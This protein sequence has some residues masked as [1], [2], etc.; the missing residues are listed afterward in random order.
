MA[1]KLNWQK[2]YEV[3]SSLRDERSFNDDTPLVFVLVMKDDTQQKR[4]V[5]FK[6]FLKFFWFIYD[7]NRITVK[8]LV[9]QDKAGNVLYKHKH[10][11]GGGEEIPQGGKP[12]LIENWS[13]LTDLQ[14]ETHLKILIAQIQNYEQPS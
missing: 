5:K 11:S 7:S 1:I 13:D 10:T 8:S 6:D 12:H 4:T 3:Q 2:I 9:V 14:K